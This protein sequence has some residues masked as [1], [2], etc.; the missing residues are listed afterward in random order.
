VPSLG[1][2][3]QTAGQPLETSPEMMAEA[4]FF[5]VREN[6]FAPAGR[7]AR[8]RPPARRSDAL[9]REA[10]GYAGGKAFEEGGRQHAD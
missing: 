10:G 6:L 2:Y 3:L 1:D 8:I 5:G 4:A 7:M 9:V